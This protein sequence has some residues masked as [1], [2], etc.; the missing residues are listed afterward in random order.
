M[1]I[2][3]MLS[4]LSILG[5]LCLSSCS[6]LQDK[7]LGP[8]K[9]QPVDSDS[10]YHNNSSDSTQIVLGPDQESLLSAF[11]RSSDA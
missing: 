8:A 6:F 5:L 4:A 2:R 1:T 3:R 10:T 7:V 9:E 11:Q